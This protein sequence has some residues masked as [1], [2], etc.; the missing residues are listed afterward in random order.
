[1]GQK[2]GQHF[3]TNTHV[4]ERIAKALEFKPRDIIIEVGAGHGELTQK[5]LDGGKELRIILVEKDP[6]LVYALEEKFGGDARV[7]ILA[8]DIRNVISEKTILSLTKGRSYK[9]AGNIPY[10]L[11]GYLLRLIGDLEHKPSLVVVTIQKEVGERI[12]A[13]EPDF[14]KLA[15]SIKFWAEPE[16]LFTISKKDF[17]PAPKVDSATLRLRSKKLGK[18]E[19][20]IEVSY[21][22]IISVLFAQPRKT[23]LNNLVSGLKRSRADITGVLMQEKISPELR[24]QHLTFPQITALAKIF[25][26]D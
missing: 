16:L 24:P 5:I 15:A 7:S 25:S 18:K 11:T 12:V 8:G 26:E 14:T 20:G 21:Y 23:I 1:M 10:Y 13:T 3:L 22:K 4:L 6:A 9:L 2:L 19:K 17:H